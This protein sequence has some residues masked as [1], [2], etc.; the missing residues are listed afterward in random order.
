MIHPIDGA[1][2]EYTALYNSAKNGHYGCVQLIIQ[3]RANVNKGDRVITLNVHTVYHHDHT[4]D[5]SNS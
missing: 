5:I 1:Q 2:D 3:S 4:H